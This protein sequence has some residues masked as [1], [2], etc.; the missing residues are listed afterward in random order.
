MTEPIET[1][2]KETFMPDRLNPFESLNQAAGNHLIGIAAKP[3][4][5]WFAVEGSAT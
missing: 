1:R 2:P 4:P 3:N 5:F